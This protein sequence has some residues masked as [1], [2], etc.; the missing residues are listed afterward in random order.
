MKVKENN[1]PN[2]NNPLIH[3]NLAHTYKKKHKLYR[4]MFFMFLKKYLNVLLGT[5]EH[6]LSDSHLLS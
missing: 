6:F 1:N 5:L 3:N 4:L 2:N